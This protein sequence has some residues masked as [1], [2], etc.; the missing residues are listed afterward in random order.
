LVADAAVGS[1]S[2]IFI[3]MRKSER[4][5]CRCPICVSIS[6]AIAKGYAADEALAV[7]IE[8]GLPRALVAA[9]G[10]MAVGDPPPG[11]EGWRIEV[12][13]LDV[14]DAP[15]PP[16]LLLKNCGVATSGDVYQ[17]LEINGVRYS[18]IIDPRTGLGLTDHSLVTIVAPDCISADSLAT[19]VSVLGPGEGQ[20]LIEET[21]N[22][23]ARIVRIPPEK[24]N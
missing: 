2:G 15:A 19:A 11:E 14:P 7:L 6:G 9:S 8:R 21:P 17:H 22:A 4:R 3:S 13:R 16:I 12:A 10:D 23:A 24:K 5:N 1:V 18:H 20:R